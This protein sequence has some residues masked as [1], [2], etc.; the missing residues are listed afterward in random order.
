MIAIG[1]PA[2]GCISSGPALSGHCASCVSGFR[3]PLRIN[4]LVPWKTTIRSTRR[5]RGLAETIDDIVVG[6][7]PEIAIGIAHCT[8]G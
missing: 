3:D 7:L 8:G 1:K 4:V 5:N 2:T 6:Q